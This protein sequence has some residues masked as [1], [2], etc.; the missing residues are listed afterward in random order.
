[1]GRGEV[2]L[3]KMKLDEITIRKKLLLRNTLPHKLFGTGLDC[4]FFRLKDAS[5]NGFQWVK[6]LW[7]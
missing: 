7:F 2:R 1:M 5:L 6:G 4:V 3:V